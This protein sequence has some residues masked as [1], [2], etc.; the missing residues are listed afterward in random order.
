MTRDDGLTSTRTTLHRVAVHVLGRG[1][2]AASG[3]FGLRAGPGGITT[4][5]FGEAP[6]TLRIS[7]TTLV[8]EVGG[9]CTWAPISGNTLRGLAELAGVDLDTTFSAGESAPGLGDA[10]QRLEVATEAA[11]VLSEWFA[12]GW[13]VLDRVIASLSAGTTATTIQLWP[14]HFDAATTVTSPS[15]E[16]VNLGFSAGDAFESEPYVYV[17]PFGPTRPGSP[18]FWNA[19]FGAVRRRSEIAGLAD[20]GA[21]CRE[22]LETGIDLVSSVPA[23]S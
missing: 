12:L 20:P 8:R 19:P 14:E 22:L 21:A 4:P 1:R 23:G 11:Q 5:A 9:E 6:E 3:R 16:P 10:D 17:G 15:S 18:V 2:F 7:G 13:H